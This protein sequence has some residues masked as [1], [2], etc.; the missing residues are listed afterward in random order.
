MSDAY[1]YLRNTPVVRWV[2]QKR[3]RTISDI[4]EKAKRNGLVFGSSMTANVEQYSVSYQ[5][6]V[7]KTGTL[8]IIS[9]YIDKCAENPGLYRNAASAVRSPK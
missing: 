1:E 2:A 9:W 3:A 6:K 8:D 5:G 4:S 7:L